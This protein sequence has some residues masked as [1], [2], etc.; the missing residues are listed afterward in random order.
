MYPWVLA[1]GFSR[2]TSRRKDCGGYNEARN[3]K[4]LEGCFRTSSSQSNVIRLELKRRDCMLCTASLPPV[5]MQRNLLARAQRVRASGVS[6]LLL[7]V[8][9]TFCRNAKLAC[10]L[11]SSYL[12]FILFIWKVVST[13]VIILRSFEVYWANIF[14]YWMKYMRWT[15][16]EGEIARNTFF[17]KYCNIVL[18]NWGW[19]DK[20]FFFVPWW[21]KHL[22]VCN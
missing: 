21:K 1:Y 8:L 17:R 18:R 9:P 3:T 5:L 20:V 7:W 12:V 19:R 15:K 13:R 11:M 22:T 6:G 16:A 2:N 4:K 10:S 14:A